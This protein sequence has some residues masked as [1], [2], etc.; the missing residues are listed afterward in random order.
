MSGRRR[1]S[2]RLIRLAN[3]WSASNECVWM[4]EDVRW[5]HKREV[6]TDG[7]S[8]VSRCTIFDER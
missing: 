3:Q 5:Q 4:R 2:L 6:E 8:F 7:P 1:E